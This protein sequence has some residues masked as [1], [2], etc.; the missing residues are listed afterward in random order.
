MDKLQTK[1]NEV[2]IKTWESICDAVESIIKAKQEAC[3]HRC[4]ATETLLW[5]LELPS[6]DF[7]D[8]ALAPKLK[9]EEIERN[10]VIAEDTIEGVI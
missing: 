10:F 2:I 6:L 4:M 3:K 8:H 9:L 7:I 5:F 1:K